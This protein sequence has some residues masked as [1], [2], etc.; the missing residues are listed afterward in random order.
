MQTILTREQVTEIITDYFNRQG[1]EV[2][3]VRFGHGPDCR[4]I[5]AIIEHDHEVQLPEVEQ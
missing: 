3:A 1:V 2:N 5:E 4:F